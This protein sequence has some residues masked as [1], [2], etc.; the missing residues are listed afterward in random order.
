VVRTS[1][2]KYFKRISVED[3]E[4]AKL[5]LSGGALTWSHE[6]ATLII[7]YKKPAAVLQARPP[8]ARAR[9]VRVSRAGPRD[10]AVRVVVMCKA[11]PPRATRPATRHTRTRHVSQLEKEA[12]EARL[13]AKDESPSGPGGK[14]GDV[15]CKSQ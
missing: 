3:M 6:N 2:K 8:R 14:E 12:K 4:R 1:N 15:D 5:P 11:V 13:N 7:Q 10:C 9:V